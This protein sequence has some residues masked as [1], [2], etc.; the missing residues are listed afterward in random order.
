MK[1]ISLFL[2]LGSLAGGLFAQQTPVMPVAA[3]QQLVTKYCAG[4]HN[5]KLKSGGFTWTKFDLAHPER[6]APQSEKVIRKLRAGMMPPAGLPRPEPE[7]LGAFA[8]ALETGV[9]R[10]AA[11]NPWAGRPALH[12]LN[13]TEYRN[14]IRNLLDLD[15]D[16]EALL[17][18]D[19]MSHGFDN[20]SDVLGISPALMDGYIRS[21]GKIA[22]LA[23]G[24]AE[25][26][27][28][29][30]TWQLSKAV[31]QLRHVVGA[32]P[33]TRGGISVVHNFPADGEYVFKAT[34]YYSID[35]PL[36]GK[37]QG[38][39]EQLEVSVN[40]DRVALF[41]IDPLRTKWDE[42]QTPPIRVK[43]GPQRVSAAFLAR[44]EGP[45]ED[46]V[47]PIEYTLVD[48]NEADMAGLTVLPHLHDLAI[49]GPWNISGISETPSRRR[50]L[51][52]HPQSAREELPCA[53]KIVSSLV[54]QAW[55]R[56]ASEADLE[57]LLNLYQTA[58]NQGGF[59]NG[60]RLALQSVIA[61]PEF[62]FRFERMPA[63]T[64]PGTRW[65]V[66]DLELASR[67]SYFLWSAPPDD[68]LLTVA[69]A[70]HLHE[71]AVL[72][73]EARRM[74][75]D[76]RAETL[77]T[78]F[79]AQWLHLQ[80]LRDVQP[81]AYLYPNFARNLA[82]SMRR[83]T[84]LLFAAIAR[85]DR[86]VP[87]LLTADYSYVDELLAKH[88]GLP[89]VLGSR[90][91][92]VEI[93]DPNRRGLLGHAGILTLT[94]VSNRTSPVQRGKYVMEV[95]L[96]TPPPAPPPNVPPLKEN[97]PS[98]DA[99]LLSVRE[100][101]EQHR[102]NEPCATCHRMIDP[103]GF[104]LENFD[105]VGGWRANDSGFPIDASGRLFDG[106]ALDGPLGLRK[107]LL[108]HQDAFLGTFTE[109]FLAYALG[110][111][112][113]SRDM[114]TVRAVQR[115]AA[116]GGNRFSAFVLGIVKST[117]FRMSQVDATPAGESSG[118]KH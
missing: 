59:D 12:R 94:S 48:L 74:L 110:R 22:R 97:P 67:L 17:P 79:A 112:I 24:D 116:R 54:R 81:D 63:G 15:V 33:G 100:R 70:G 23:L 31:N 92:R 11:S 5:D 117:P 29:V 61:N 28:A 36:Y 71:P 76:P 25:A 40:G 82:D 18:A 75:A 98:G 102:A 49:A 118:G 101:Q 39:S 115:E 85:E 43:A 4:C 99:K 16:V 14:S 103:I 113:D 64:A 9:D 35:G 78:N 34:F 86:P 72:E 108:S 20:M 32:P 2:V 10:T 37:S 53:R 58:R 89:N 93:R 84:E 109:S 114:P 27:P 104:A 105:A 68:R 90:F 8:S 45:V 44:A 56:P 73:R 60:I 46:V 1:P 106:S 69:A 41:D 55:R 7:T 42:M 88:Y 80:N 107:A 26:A 95:L 50:V 6:N 91:R 30:A 13:R 111:V 77:S 83:E 66:S 57:E 62:V 96:G 38:K 3:Q 52:C 19:D 65:T 87:E 51:V 47:S 21:A